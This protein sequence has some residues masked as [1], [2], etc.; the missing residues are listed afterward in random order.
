[1]L[2]KQIKKILSFV[3]V[4][5]M[6]LGTISTTTFAEDYPE[7]TGA[8]VE[9]TEL[10]GE[11]GTVEVTVEGTSLPDKIWYVLQEKDMYWSTLS[12]TVAEADLVDGKIQVTIPANTST[13]D[14]TMRIRVSDS[15]SVQYYGKTTGSFTLKGNEN[16]EPVV[17]PDYKK[18]TFEVVDENDH[19]MKESV[20]FKL[21]D[22]VKSEYFGDT[23]TVSDIT[24]VDGTFSLEKSSSD[25]DDHTYTVSLADGTE[26]TAEPEFIELETDWQKF[27]K[28]ANASYDGLTVYKFKLTKKSEP[29]P[30][31][32]A[33]TKKVTFEFVDESGVKI[34][35]PVKLVITDP[36]EDLDD[37][38]V[39]AENGIYVFNSAGNEY[40]EECVIK[41]AE[42]SG[43]TSEPEE[44]SLLVK[45]YTGE[46]DIFMVGSDYY[47]GQ[48]KY[49]FVLKKVDTPTPE[50]ADKTALKEQIDKT[51]YNTSIYTP[52][53]W[54]NYENQLEAAKKVYDKADATQQEVDDALQALKDAEK[55]LKKIILYSVTADVAELPS[56]GG[57]V[58]V[59]INSENV[60]KLWYAVQIKDGEYW[61]YVDGL[62]GTVFLNDEKNTFTV[63]LPEN[64]TDSEKEYRVAANE[65][66]PLPHSWSMYPSYSSF[67]DTIKVKA[68]EVTPDPE[69]QPVL[70]SVKALATELTSEGGLVDFEVNEK[71]VK[72]VWYKLQKQCDT[73][74]GTWKTEGT[75]TKAE[76]KDGIFQVA[77]PANTTTDDINYRLLVD[78]NDSGM[79]MA[80]KT[81]AIT[82][83]AAAT[84]DD[85]VADMTKITFE[86]VDENGTLITTPIKLVIEDLDGVE[87]PVDAV[88]ENGTFTYDATESIYDSGCAVKLEAD[89]GYT[90]SPEEYSFPVVNYKGE[91]VISYVGDEYYDGLKVYRF[92]L[93]KN[94]DPAS[95]SVKVATFNYRNAEKEGNTTTKLEIRSLDEGNPMPEIASKE[96]ASGESGNF[97]EI[98]FTNPGTYR[99]EVVMI[100]DGE[101]NVLYTCTYEVTEVDNKLE[102]TSEIE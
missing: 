1:M 54:S 70:Y 32:V 57:D 98:E 12:D 60:S 65:Q 41:L 85:K 89:S 46:D 59:T 28:V 9:I 26:Y 37:V 71:T 38:N 90:S 73:C 20:A 56:A 74:G 92:V 102:V 27:T 52:E 99:Y 36:V 53:S 30:E 87:D 3:L 14:K 79:N 16:A 34:T 58:S 76:V 31:P 66:N 80:Y 69:P 61:S 75:L 5:A 62:E 81:D 15:K 77:L 4:M 86:F 29:E 8:S 42:D 25:Y 50:E 83:K 24:S 19:L 78:D 39:V 84:P 68:A 48:T 45:K 33:D 7:V 51:F 82:V 17:T 10:P 95:E 22:V 94:E 2:R 96:F 35:D 21:K 47:D 13:E 93:T 91:Q 49:S 67:T 64:T 88:A 97:G 100:K 18:V 6:M 11:G 101:E 63:T 43:Y 55:A 40:E 23:E 44:Y 72:E